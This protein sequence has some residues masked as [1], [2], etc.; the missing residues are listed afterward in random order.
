MGRV[1]FHTLG[2]RVNQYETEGIKLQ[3]LKKGYEV[4]DFDDV[5]DV[6]VVNTCTVTSVADKK[7]RNFLRRPK[8]IN[9]DAIV[10]ATGCYAQTNPNDLAKIE[11]VDLVVGQKEKHFITTLVDNYEEYRGKRKAF[12]GN[13]FKYETYL[14]SDFA[15][16]R[17]IDKAYIKIQDGCDRFCSFCKI[18][19]ARGTKR[20]RDIISII[21]ECKKVISEGFREIVL[22]GIHL[23]AYGEDLDGTC[24]LDDVVEKVLELDGLTRLRVSSIYPDTISDRFIDLMLHPKLMP[25][26]HVSIQSADDNVL[27]LMRR[28]Y[29][30]KLMYDVFDKIRNK[31]KDVAFTGD[32]IV[33]FPGESEENFMNTYNFIKEFNFSDLHIFPYSDREKTASKNF[34]NKV[35]N[36]VKYDRFKR[37]DALKKVSKQN[38]LNRYLGK[39]IEVLVE[40]SKGNIAKGYT[41][42]FLKSC[43][44]TSAKSKEIITFVPERAVDGILYGSEI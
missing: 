35:P 31:V 30:S 29:D 33:G 6:Y 32:V 10:I 36:I 43:I 8:K 27:K 19:F 21:D 25:H 26:L 44:E 15:T 3:F 42:N 37:L 24:S 17:E 34:D 20:S 23:G 9:S 16:L 14:D 40:S 7:N 28:R 1:A 2:C 12:V 11:D 13:V 5:A 18:P 38:F 39:P 4:V 41:N 22:I